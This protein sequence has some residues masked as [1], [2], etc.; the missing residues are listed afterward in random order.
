MAEELKLT[1]IRDDCPD[2]RTC[3]AVHRT[4]RYSLMIIGRQVTEPASAGHAQPDPGRAV[5][6]VPAS[7]VPEL[8]A[9]RTS[10]DTVVITGRLVTEPAA[11]AQMDIGP[12]EIAIEVP[13]AVLA[14]AA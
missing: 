14:G 7:L 2:N 8:A 5:I 4:N 12:G 1:K 3:P 9:S 10:R 6:E 13:A 11:L